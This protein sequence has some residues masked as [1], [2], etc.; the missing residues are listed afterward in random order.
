MT[1]TR[2]RK[3]LL[4]LKSNAWTTLIV[5][6]QK[7]E[8]SVEHESIENKLSEMENNKQT[9]HYLNQ[10]ITEKEI[11]ELSKKLK[12]KKAAFSDKL[13]DEMIKNSIDILCPAYKKIFNLILQ[14]VIYPDSW[15]EGSITPIFKAGDHSDP[16]NNRGICLSSCLAL[17]KFFSSILN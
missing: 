3:F 9:N 8:N 14:C 12:S 17:G 6:N 11:K 2:K 10:P 15:C 7:I 13:K 4:L 5:S 16:N 1:N